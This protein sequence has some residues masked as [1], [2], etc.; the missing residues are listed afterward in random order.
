MSSLQQPGGNDP[1]KGPGRS[2]GK[3]KPE[4]QVASPPKRNKNEMD[5]DPEWQEFLA[6]WDEDFFNTAGN[7]QWVREQ[8]EQM[9]IREARLN[10]VNN[11]PNNDKD[12]KANH[13]GTNGTK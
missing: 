13:N 9:R 7:A 5:G 8:Q 6:N 12:N 1:N 11:Q 4:D 10:Q 3:R 2:P